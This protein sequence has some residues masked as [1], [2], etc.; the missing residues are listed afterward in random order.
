MKPKAG[1]MLVGVLTFSVGAWLSF[2][3][4]VALMVFG[5]LLILDAKWSRA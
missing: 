4:P 3:G 5:A 2:D 1:I